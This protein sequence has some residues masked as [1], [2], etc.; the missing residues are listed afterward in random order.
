MQRYEYDSGARPLR[1][2]R[3]KWF[4]AGVVAILIAVFLLYWFVLRAEPNP[5]PV[6]SAE[7]PATNIEPQPTAVSGRYLFNGTIVLARMVE[8]AAGNDLRLPFSGL[9]TFKPNQYDTMTLDWECPTTE[10]IIPYQ[11]QVDNLLFNCH[12]KWLPEVVKHFGIVS[13]ASNHTNDLGEDAYQETQKNLNS[14]GIQTYGS[15]DPSVAEDACEVI[16]LPVRVAMPDGSE[17]KSTLPMAFCSWMYFGREPRA[18]EMEVMQ[19]FAA[20]MPV[21]GFQHTGVEYRNPA[22]AD[23]VNVAHKMIDLGAEFSIGNSPHWV[24]NGEVYKGKPIFY[25]T[26]NFIFDQIDYET[27]RGLSIDVRMKIPY[28]E[29]V[30]KWLELAKSCNPQ[31]RHDDC[32]AQAKDMGL[33]KYGIELTY[34]VVGSSGGSR[35][36][37]K[38]AD[39][40]LQKAIEQRVGWEAMKVKLNQ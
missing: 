28:N 3:R 13:L 38:K 27:M 11:T 2:N 21:F 4:I 31:T 24:Q 25:S 14:A 33:T 17:T 16:G 36:I 26:G 20:V 9:S 40:T 8:R 19:Q 34:D 15:Y 39:T 6:N 29:T 37:T 1:R 5:A 22:G 18:G 12:K 23:Q 35:R 30:A 7:Q 32:L 10:D